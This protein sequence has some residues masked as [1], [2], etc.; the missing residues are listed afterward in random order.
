MRAPSTGPLAL[1]IAAGLTAGLTALVLP[2]TVTT[3]ESVVVETRAVGDTLEEIMGVRPTTTTDAHMAVLATLLLVIA[4]VCLASAG[5]LALRRARPAGRLL[6][7]AAGLSAVEALVAV[8]LP[9]PE[10]SPDAAVPAVA[11][12]VVG[13]LVVAAAFWA[14]EHR[15][16]ERPTSVPA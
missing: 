4:A 2:V 10:R 13:V 1:A 16:S 12:L 6:A 14:R 7:A 5:L 3:G 15:S 8:G 11:A 9:V